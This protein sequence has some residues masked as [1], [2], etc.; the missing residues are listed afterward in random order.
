[1]LTSA[2]TIDGY[3]ATGKDKAVIK[4]PNISINATHIATTGRLIKNSYITPF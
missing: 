1:M 4:P 2:G 3:C